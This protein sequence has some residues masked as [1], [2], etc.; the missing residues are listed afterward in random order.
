MASLESSETEFQQLMQDMA[1]GSEEA[2]WK[3]TEIYTPHIMRSIRASLPKAIRQK[4]DSQDYAQAVW[5]SILLREKDFHRFNSP[6]QFIG[7][8]TAMAR[9]KVID[10]YRRFTK[11]QAYS[12]KRETSLD[13]AEYSD[14]ASTD[15][16]LVVSRELPAS[17]VVRVKEQ[18]SVAL[19][20][21][22]ERDR[23]IVDL[24][25]AGQDLQQIAD[26]LK[27]NEKTV[28]RA[29]QRVLSQMAS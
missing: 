18:W 22:S 19:E 26:E 9:N 8:L 12:I 27:I 7:Y 16:Q 3:I 14:E 28:R 10:N 25:I 13:A 5:A 21:C 6:G 11:T 17:Q 24:R 20:S 2:A 15:R 1:D 23:R 4:A 29:L